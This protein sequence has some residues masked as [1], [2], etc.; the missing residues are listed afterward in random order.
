MKNFTFS[1]YCTPAYL[2]IAL[3]VAI[4]I[5]AFLSGLKKETLALEALFIGVWALGLQWLCS[6]G[7]KII[8]WSLAVVPVILALYMVIL[9]KND[10]ATKEGIDNKTPGT[11]GDNISKT[12][13]GDNTKDKRD[14]ISNVKT[15]L[16]NAIRARFVANSYIKSYNNA[17]PFAATKRA[18]AEK[19]T[20]DANN[21][22][23]AIKEKAAAARNSVNANP[24]S[25]VA[26]IDS[27]LAPYWRNAYNT[28]K[29]ALA[30][31]KE[32]QY[33]QNNSNNAL[34]KSN[35]ALNVATAAEAAYNSAASD[36]E[37]KYPYDYTSIATQAA[38]A[39]K[40]PIAKII[41]Q[42]VSAIKKAEFLQVSPPDIIRSNIYPGKT[43]Q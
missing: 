17:V 5:G 12:P 31:I 33:V 34:E 13:G 21:A 27:G 19:A 37:S 2:N 39:F 23:A 11:A 40:T 15:L 14:A 16:D 28:Y 18:I 29:A 4:L 24:K 38:A 42:D 41:Q 3:G 25:D 30:A 7:Y 35:N 20:K 22:Y 1:K 9:V 32:Y 26:K 6:K 36:V 10:V 8:S 43:K